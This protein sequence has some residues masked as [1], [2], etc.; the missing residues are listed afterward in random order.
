MR[1]DRGHVRPGKPARERGMMGRKP[2]DLRID[3]VKQR[4]TEK[5]FKEVN[6]AHYP[7]H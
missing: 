4:A 7:S 5:Y 3:I 2:V 6:S 1:E